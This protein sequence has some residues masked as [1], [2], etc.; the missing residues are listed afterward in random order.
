MQ[1]RS[2]CRLV[3]LFKFLH[4][5]QTICALLC[6]AGLASIRP[7]GE[8]GADGE[9]VLLRSDFLLFAN[10]LLTTRSRGRLASDLAAEAAASRR[11]AALGQTV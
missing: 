2:I 10:E 11:A 9:A 5:L 3:G 4:L 1:H 7:A 8:N 6:Q